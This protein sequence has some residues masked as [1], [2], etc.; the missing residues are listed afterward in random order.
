M[1]AGD[2]PADHHRSD[3]R[4]EAYTF[5]EGYA[6]K[7]LFKL[8][9]VG[10]VVAA[11]VKTIAAKKAEWQGLTESQV[12]DKLHAKL[13]DRMPAEKV[14]ELGTK[15]VDAMRQ[16]GVLGEDAEATEEPTD[17]ASEEAPDEASD[18]T[19]D[20]ETDEASTVTE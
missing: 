13:D 5:R 16:R 20:E 9:L 3:A 10:A 8:A 14:D 17:E 7:K 4:L 19:T 12:R 11:I 2:R 18:E 6:V 1:C 15:V